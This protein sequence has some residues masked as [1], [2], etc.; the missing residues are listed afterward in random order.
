M[1]VETTGLRLRQ[2]EHIRKIGEELKQRDTFKGIGVLSLS[3]RI[4]LL[5][6]GIFPISLLSE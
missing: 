1:D 4:F 5:N 6:K 3:T 2:M